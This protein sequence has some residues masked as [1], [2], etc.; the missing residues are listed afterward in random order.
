MQT[1][2]LA[3][4][5]AGDLDRDG[6]VRL[7]ALVSPDQLAAMQRAFSSVLERQRWNDFDGY[8][9]TERLRHMVQNVLT[10][11]QGFVDIAIHPLVKDILHRYIGGRFE[12]VEAKGWKS[13]PT[14]KDF[15]G[16]HGD[17]WYD[18][19]KA[20]DIPREVKLGL[21]LT[22]V[23][24]GAFNY[25]I[26]THRQQAPHPLRDD[27]VN[28]LPRDRVVEVLGQGGSGFLFDTSGVH[29]QAMPILEDRQAVFYN[30][31][32]P[33]VALQPEDLDYYRYHPLIL[34]AAFLGNLS[35]D[36]RQILGFGNK[37][38]Y[39]PAFQRRPRHEL[40]QRVVRTAYETKL[41]TDELAQRL[42]A[43]ARRTFG[44]GKR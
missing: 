18:Q 17:A 32:D 21:Y 23:K 27:E 29:R 12:L 43:R 7:P 28:G 6:L 11:E 14:R 16:W 37:S 39:V 36:D 24:S 10:L 30:Y 38:N 13:L 20:K 42:T 3:K 35:D 26:G 8:E 4:Q 1:A 5:L 41:V 34:N 9:K 31:H 44:L 22:D 15:H 19:T 2:E 33:S 40:F 25:I